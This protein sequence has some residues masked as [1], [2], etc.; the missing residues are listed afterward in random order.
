MSRALLTLLTVLLSVP[1]HLA[2]QADSSPPPPSIAILRFGPSPAVTLTEGAIL[3][4]LESYGFITS[5]ENRMLEERQNLKGE[6]LSVYWGDAGSN[7]A[8]VDLMIE[9]ALDEGLDAI[10]ALSTPVAQIATAITSDMDDPPA[11]L[12]AMVQVPY[13]AGIAD[14]SCIKPDHVG[15]ALIESDYE[16]VLDALR[17]QDPDL[18]TVGFVYSTSLAAGEYAYQRINEVAGDMGIEALDAGII[19]LADLSAAAQGLIDRGAMAL[20]V[21]GDYLMTAGLPIVVSVANENAVPVFHPSAGGI[22]SGLTIGTGYSTF[23]S[24]GDKI[25]VMLAGRL[26]G[27]LDLAA[28]MIHHDVA[29]RDTEFLDINLDSAAEQDIE[30]SQALLDQARAMIVV[31]EGTLSLPQTSPVV[32]QEFARQGVVVPMEDRLEADMAFLASLECAAE[33]IAEQQA[34]LDAAE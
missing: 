3:D 7:L 27:D 2:A 16:T 11:V 23:Y 4:V 31:S 14:S 8:T 22:M 33:M 10:I 6:N 24:G 30:I 34:E 13:R 20:L 19:A 5:D 21:A 25:G 17:L 15:G 29:A 18:D 32:L 28:S 26:N 1:L 9:A 12:V